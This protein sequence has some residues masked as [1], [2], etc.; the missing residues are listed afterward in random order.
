MGNFSKFQ[1]CLV[2]GKPKVLPASGGNVLARNGNLWIF[3]GEPTLDDT[4]TVI[5]SLQKGFKFCMFTSRGM[6]LTRGAN[7]DLDLCSDSQWSVVI[8]V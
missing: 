3:L 4:T 2:W 5:L 1:K 6:S 8:F 7:G